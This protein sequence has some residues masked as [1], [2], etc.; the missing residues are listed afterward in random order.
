[1]NYFKTQQIESQCTSIPLLYELTQK[2]SSFNHGES[3]KETE[4]KD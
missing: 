4:T 1:M 2:L 3:K